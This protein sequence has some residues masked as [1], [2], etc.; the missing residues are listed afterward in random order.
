IEELVLDKKSGEV[1][2]AVLSSGGFMHMGS[3]FYAI[4]WKKLEYCPKENAFRMTISKDALKSAPG[5]NKGHWP[6]FANSLW[7][8]PVD[9]FYWL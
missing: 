2:Y 3:D 7:S 1:R 8:K 9:D 5:F 4:P 6:D